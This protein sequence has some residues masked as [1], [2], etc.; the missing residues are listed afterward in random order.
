MTMTIDSAAPAGTADD[1]GSRNGTTCTQDRLCPPWCD[2]D[3]HDDSDGGEMHHTL[4]WSVPVSAYSWT[5]AR[6]ERCLDWINVSRKQVRD[7]QP[8]I[9]IEAPGQADAEDPDGLITVPGQFI[10]TTAEA[11]D[12][13][14]TLLN[15]A[16]SQEMRLADADQDSGKSGPAVPGGVALE[17]A[18][19][20]VNVAALA[21][22][23]A[24][25]APGD[26]SPCCPEDRLEL[27][28]YPAVFCPDCGSLY[29]LRTGHPVNAPN[30]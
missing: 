7:G 13:A 18:G 30:G 16:A 28:R 17:A 24:S 1:H 23:A 26:Q 6:G 19:A 10:V 20:L 11:V 22:S 2:I 9:L 4:T 21:D 3:N 12:L 29:V 25:Y 14:V 27:F 8:V 5:E 15:L